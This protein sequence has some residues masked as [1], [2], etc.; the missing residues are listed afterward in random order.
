MNPQPPPPPLAYALVSL[1][2]VRV[3]VVTSLSLKGFLLAFS[4][5]NDVLEKVEAIFLDNG[6]SFQAASKALPQLLKSPE[7]RNSLRGKGI[8]WEF[9]PQYAPAQDGSWES[10]VKQ[11]K[12]ILQK[13]LETATHKLSLMELITCC[14]NA[15][16][17]VNER[18]FTALNDDPG[19]FAVVTPASLLNTG[20]DTYTPVGR[21][22]DRDH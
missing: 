6:S 8:Q 16:R 4:R 5:F 17:V 11:V 3:E 14:S 18:P 21:A 13:T 20:F 2:S 7:L 19:D 9:I 12:R 15:V 22:H 10:M 1:R